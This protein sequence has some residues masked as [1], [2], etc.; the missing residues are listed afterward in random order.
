MSRAT[1]GLAIHI[2]PH[3]SYRPGSTITGHVHRRV[4]VLVGDNDVTVTISLVGCSH[5]TVTQWSDHLGES[6]QTYSSS[7]RFLDPDATLTLHAGPL[8]IPRTEPGLAHDVL[9]PGDALPEDGK[10]WPFEITVPLRTASKQVRFDGCLDGERQDVPHGVVEECVRRGRA[11]RVLEGSELPGTG[12]LRKREFAPGEFV[13]SGIHYFLEARL[14]SAGANSRPLAVAAVVIE[15][16]GED[17][18]D[19]EDGGD[20]GRT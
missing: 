5:V 2:P 14:V 15:A 7:T 3:P 20:G 17:G 11:R 9:R 16:D 4:P 1:K 12:V 13:E 18:E 8:H 10:S 6:Q 19:G